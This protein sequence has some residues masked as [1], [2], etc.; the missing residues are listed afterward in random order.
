MVSD[1]KFT[2]EYCTRINVLF[3]LGNSDLITCTVVSKDGKQTRRF[4]AM[5]N[6]QLILVE[7]HSKMMGWGV[8]K[9]AGFLEDIEVS[10]RY[11]LFF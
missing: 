11:L 2:Y 8:T 5:D 7:P 3:L 9:L 6:N 4:I 1:D 10:N